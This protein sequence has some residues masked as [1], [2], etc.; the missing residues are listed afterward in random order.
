MAEELAGLAVVKNEGD[1]IEAMV[2]HNLRF[3]DRLHIIDNDSADATPDILAA[4]ADEFSGRLTWEIDRQTGHMQTAIVNAALG[5]L[6]TRTGAKQ[7]VLFD[8]DEFLRADVTVFRET[9]LVERRPLLLPWVTYVPTSGDDTTVLNPSERIT[10][11]RCLENQPFYKVTI[12]AHLVGRV[13]VTAGNHSLRRAGDSVAIAVEGLSL[14]HFPVRSAEQLTSKVLIGTWNMRLRGSRRGREGSHWHKLAARVLAGH[15]IDD[16]DV[17]EIATGYSSLSPSGI[18]P[19]PLAAV[20]TTA[21]KYTPDGKAN[22]LRNLAAFTESC[23]RL[24]E[25]AKEQGNPTESSGQD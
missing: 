23:V 10:N 24:L 11:R 9:L 8:A 7:I 1:I 21:L 16:N 14:A 22:L 18:Q 12:P 25:N 6:L 3:V 17:Q 13:R 20:G 4:L 19:D 5:P 2:R 15:V